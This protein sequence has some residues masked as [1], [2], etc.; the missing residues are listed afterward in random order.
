MFT[1]TNFAMFTGLLLAAK[2]LSV[3]PDPFNKVKA[4][5]DLASG[6]KKLAAALATAGLTPLATEM[7]ARARDADRAFARES[8]AGD[9][10]AIFWQVAPTALADTSA[11]AAADLDPS[12]EITNRMVAAIRASPP[13][14]RLAQ[15]PMAEP[16]F[17]SV[18]QPTLAAMATVPEATLIAM[19]RKISPRVANRDE[20]LRE[21]DAAVDRAAEGQIARGEAGSN[22]DTFIGAALPPTRRPDRRR[23]GSTPRQPPPT[24]QWSKSMP[25]CLELIERRRGPST[26]DRLRRGRGRRG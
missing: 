2:R 5:A 24:T 13:R 12:S 6:A 17:R 8:P 15:A 7:E 10:R 19:A 23:A 22:V 11:M 9:A 25:D 1:V 4:V 14:D 18:V 26:P 16:Y 20:A 3:D 21:L